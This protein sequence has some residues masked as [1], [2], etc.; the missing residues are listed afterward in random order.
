VRVIVNAD[1]LGL[2]VEIN[3]AIERAL[4]LGWCSSTSLMANGPAFEDAAG[5]LRG[6]GSPPVGVHLNLSEGPPL[7]HHPG[8]TP[9]LQGGTLSPL[10][11][12]AGPAERAAVLGEWAAQIERVRAAGLVIS[13]L[14]SHQHLHHQP[15]LFGVV[16]ELRRRFGL[17]R[18]RTMG[19]WRLGVG[20]RGL[21][22]WL[23][24]RRFRRA[25]RADGALT[26]DEFMSVRVFR[27]LLRDPLHRRL[28]RGASVE[29]MAHPGNPHDPTYREELDWLAAGGLSAVR[30]P[31]RLLSWAQLS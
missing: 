27:A 12:H 18:T 29:L 7:T 5:R 10:G 14:D 25:L 24:A 11:L 8:L 1:D 21:A 15:L 28:L 23:R 31:L 3:E 6:L 19:A 4:R 17:R 30:G 26:T 16:A 13:H 2:S 9:L 20:A 22:Q